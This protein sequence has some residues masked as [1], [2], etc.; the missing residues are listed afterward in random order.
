M[1]QLSVLYDQERSYLLEQAVKA[2]GCQGDEAAKFVDYIREA[3]QSAT[4]QGG[5][6]GPGGGGPP[7][8]G[9]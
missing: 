1:A 7:P 6:G 2:A 3:T 4:M 9:L 8:G 5:P